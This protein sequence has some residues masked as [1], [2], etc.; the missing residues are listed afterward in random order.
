[1]SGHFGLSTQ[2]YTHFTSPIRRYPDLQ[3]HRIIK[4]NLHGRLNQ[5][6]VEHYEKILPYV[7]EQSSKLERRAQNA[8][9]EVE[10]LKKVEYMQNYLG[11][12]F[13]GVISG[14]TARGFFVELENTVEGLVPINRLLD[15][16]YL[17]EEEQYQLRGERTGRIFTLGQKVYCGRMRG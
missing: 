3:I 13:D 14:V 5:K 1:M 12:V 16:Y 10:K 2:Y 6:R 11:E 7:T 4:E 8:E 9:R 17:F 15:D